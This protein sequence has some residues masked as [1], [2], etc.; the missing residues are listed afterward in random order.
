MSSKTNKALICNCLVWSPLSRV[1]FQLIHEFLL[2]HISSVWTSACYMKY[3][4]VSKTQ[5]MMNDGNVM[6]MLRGNISVWYWFFFPVI[7]LS[8]CVCVIYMP[9]SCFFYCFTHQR[10]SMYFLWLELCSLSHVCMFFFFNVETHL[11]RN[12][13]EGSH[14]EKPCVSL[15]SFKETHTE[16]VIIDIKLHV[17][18]RPWCVSSGL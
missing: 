4:P 17:A 3:V 1:C 11:M 18:Q 2:S 9:I 16:K 10:S 15:P 7:R 12:C 6:L 5:M 8:V 14:N 13:A